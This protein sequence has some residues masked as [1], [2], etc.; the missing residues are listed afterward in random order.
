MKLFYTP[1]LLILA[2][3]GFAAAETLTWSYGNVWNTTETNWN[4]EQ[5]ASVPWANTGDDEAVFDSIA[6]LT[7]SGTI[8]LCA[9]R[10]TDGSYNLYSQTTLEEGTL[11][12]GTARGLIDSSV[13]PQ[14]A[15][16][17]IGSNL[18]G[19]AGL[20]IASNYDMDSGR[21]GIILSGDNT[22]L[23]GGI[24]IVSG[25]VIFL[26]QEAAG[27]GSITLDGGAISPE[28]HFSLT[29]SNDLVIGDAGGAIMPLGTLNLTGRISGS[30]DLIAYGGSVFW[31]DL[32]NYTGTLRHPNGLVS[33]KGV[34]K[35]IRHFHTDAKPLEGGTLIHWLTIDSGTTV[36]VNRITG[37]ILNQSGGHLI[38]DGDNTHTDTII[39]GDGATLT[40]G[41]GGTTG[42]LGNGY[43]RINTGS[44]LRFNRSDS[45]E[46]FNLIKGEGDVEIVSGTIILSGVNEYTGTTTVRDGA[47]LI[48]ADDFAFGNALSGTADLVIEQNARLMVAYGINLQGIEDLYAAGSTIVFFD[49]TSQLSINGT[50]NLDGATLDLTGFSEGSYD[51]NDLFGTTDYDFAAANLTIKTSFQHQWNGSSGLWIT[52]AIPEPSASLLGLMACSVLLRRRIR[53]V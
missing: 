6:R 44:T 39:S 5:S 4:D 42:T 15:I 32:S 7:V 33:L 19:Q 46:A 47:T 13:V 18:T 43:V 49:E 41:K 40:I 21:G 36:T 50:L 27:H 8:N 24:T 52:S 1:V 11:N 31:D 17:Q 53:P 16:T 48:A 25:L 20:T 37:N 9:L 2:L 12:F 45:Y 23:A 26:T 3:T 14:D 35:T 51:L 38:A 29:L 28:Y 30:G 10:F 34:D 22:G